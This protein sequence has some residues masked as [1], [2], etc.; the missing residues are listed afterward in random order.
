MTPARQQALHGKRWEGDADAQRAY[1]QDNKVEPLDR[2]LVELAPKAWLAGLRRHQTQ[3]RK[4]LNVVEVHQGIYKVH[5][6][7]NW[8]EEQ[9][10]EYMRQHHLPYHP[11][12]EKG[13][14]SIGD[15]HSTFPVFE[16]E[17]SRAGRLLGTHRECGIHLPRE[18][19]RRSSAL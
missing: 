5:P 13:Y 7:L 8:S 3:F 19:S 16:G 4:Q 18:Q 12:Y 14:R 17:D 2:A 11:L 10:A 6:I 9:V 15:E 1:L